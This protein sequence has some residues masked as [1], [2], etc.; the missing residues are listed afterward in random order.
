MDKCNPLL[1]YFIK[2]VLKIEIPQPSFLTAFLIN[3]PIN[4]NVYFIAHGVWKDTQ[5]ELYI[6]IYIYLFFTSCV[7]F[8][9]P[10]NKQNF[11]KLLT[12]CEMYS[13]PGSSI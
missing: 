11:P 10:T 1:I 6:Y 12:P 8:T 7:N 5:V 2:S 13:R 9:L 4:T 3:F